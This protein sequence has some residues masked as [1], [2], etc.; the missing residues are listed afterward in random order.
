LVAQL[1]ASAGAA[2][3][4]LHVAVLDR[5][6]LTRAQLPDGSQQIT[7]HRDVLLLEVLQ[8]LLI[9]RALQ[10]PATDTS[11]CGGSLSIFIFT[12]STVLNFSIAS[13]QW[14]PRASWPT[15]TV[16]TATSVPLA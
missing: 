13:Q 9:H 12:I 6:M 5:V 2:P 15:Y 4:W 14:M 10:F 7:V 16:S 1:V 11:V 3:R 8:L